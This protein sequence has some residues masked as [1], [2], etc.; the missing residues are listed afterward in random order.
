[1]FVTAHLVPDGTTVRAGSAR[2]QPLPQGSG[3][4]A[5]ASASSAPVTSNFNDDLQKSIVRLPR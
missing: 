1:V 3:A 2:M 5:P 4:S